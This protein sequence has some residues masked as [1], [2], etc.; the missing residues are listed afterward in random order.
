MLSLP[1]C[2]ECHDELEKMI[3]FDEKKPREFYFV[4]V[5]EFLDLCEERPED[6]N[7]E[8]FLAEI[9]PVIISWAKDK[10]EDRPMATILSAVA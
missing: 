3:P 6:L 2:R 10:Y 9:L 5:I 7:S 8:Q 4:I 1:L